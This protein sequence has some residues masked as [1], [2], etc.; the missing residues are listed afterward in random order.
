M[1]AAGADISI[2][3][4]GGPVKDGD[5]DSHGQPA[6]PPGKVKLCLYSEPVQVNVTISRTDPFEISRTDPFTTRLR[7]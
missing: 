2:E 1:I 6:L 5:M 7:L 4:D 3:M